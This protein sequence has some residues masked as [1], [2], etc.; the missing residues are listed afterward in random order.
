M[1]IGFHTQKQL[2]EEQEREEY[3]ELREEFSDYI[4][5]LLEAQKPKEW[6]YIIENINLL[7]SKLFQWEKH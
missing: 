3:N 5:R 1:T 6:K 7:L 4:Y 2:E